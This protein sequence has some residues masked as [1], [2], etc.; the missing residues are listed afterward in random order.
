MCSPL[1]KLVC[2]CLVVT[3]SLPG[4]NAEWSE[5]CS[6][7][8]R[9]KV[10]PGVRNLQG[11]EQTPPSSGEA[12]GPQRPLFTWGGRQTHQVIK[13]KQPW[14]Q[15]CG[16][17][18]SWVLGTAGTQP[19]GAYIWPPG[20]ESKTTLTVSQE[21]SGESGRLEL[22][23]ERTRPLSRL[24]EDSGRSP[25]EKLCLLRPT[26]R[27]PT[28]WTQRHDDLQALTSGGSLIFFCCLQPPWLWFMKIIASRSPNQVS[29]ALAT[30]WSHPGTSRKRWWPWDWDIYWLGWGRAGGFGSF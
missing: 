7:F 10:S 3:V 19:Q 2:P 27:L 1:G 14:L 18:W 4:K 5:E 28:R 13:E 30:H 26:D 9:A 29:S 22:D 23:P 16:L 6:D 11:R 8:H 21:Q 25:E 12:A 17:A 24:R 20:R 15:L